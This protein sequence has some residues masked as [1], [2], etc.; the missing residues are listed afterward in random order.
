MNQMSIDF[1]PGLAERYDR[2]M[3]C[4]RASVYSNDKP[5]KAIAS[6]MDI[7]QS[8]LSRKL[9][10]NPND[11]RH[12]SV[13]DLERYMD[14]TGDTRPV[15]YLAEKYLADKSMRQQAALHE[16]AKRLPDLVA[17]MKSAGVK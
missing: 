12:F 15:Q 10:E 6:D 4:V 14:A 17:L 11:T 13:D 2:A 7:S 5:L 16:L 8:E 1:E 9:A 3:D